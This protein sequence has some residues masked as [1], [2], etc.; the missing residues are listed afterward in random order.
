MVQGH[1]FISTAGV[2]PLKCFDMILGEDW[3]ESCSPMWIHWAKKFMRFTHYGKRIQ[4]QGLQQD[5]NQYA[6]ISVLDCKGCSVS[7]I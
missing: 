2:L 5:L 6:S 7:R 4:L 1:S 3:L